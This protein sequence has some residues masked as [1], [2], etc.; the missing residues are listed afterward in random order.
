MCVDTMY[1]N[2]FNTALEK[3]EMN[4]HNNITDMEG[5]W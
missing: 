4:S 3:K 1:Q 5:F 2:N